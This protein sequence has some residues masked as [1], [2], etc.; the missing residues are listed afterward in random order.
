MFVC[1]VGALIFNQ[2]NRVFEENTP[3]SDGRHRRY[4][5]NINLTD[6]RW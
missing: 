6:Q 4:V 2:L 5:P 3:T 1:H